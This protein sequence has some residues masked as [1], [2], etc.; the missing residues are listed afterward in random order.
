MRQ[1]QYTSNIAC[2]AGVDAIPRRIIPAAELFVYLLMPL[3]LVRLVTPSHALLSDTH[4]TDPLHQQ[5][6]RR[7]VLI[8]ALH[9]AVAWRTWGIWHDHAMEQA[10]ALLLQLA[11]MHCHS[12]ILYPLR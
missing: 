12:N 5:L 4:P 10:T 9:A 3:Q 1:Q 2:R 8:Q 6:S 11:S 7:T